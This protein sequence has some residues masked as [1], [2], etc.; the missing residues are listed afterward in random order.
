MCRITYTDASTA[1]RAEPAL[2]PPEAGEGGRDLADVIGIDTGGT[3]TDFVLVRDGTIVTLKAPSTPDD[4]ARAAV[5]GMVT[6]GSEAAVVVHG[7][8]VATNALLE[9]KGARTALVTTAGFEDVL[10]LGRQAR[11][12]LYALEYEAPEPLI[13]PGR[14]V[15]V[16]ERVGAD[17]SVVA[18]LSDADARRVAEAVAALDIEAVAVS[19][20]FSFLRPEHEQRLAAAIER[21]LPEV[22]IS[23]SSDVLPEFRE[24]E[25]ASTVS[26]NAYVGPLMSGYLGR[27][28]QRLNVP[29]RVM[30][31]SGGSTPVELA[32]R[33]PVRTVLSGPAG[34]VIGGMYV[35]EAAGFDHVI[36][37]DMGGT[38]TDVALIPGRVQ[39]TTGHTVGTV[40][41]GVPAVDI[42]TVGA[43]GGSIARVD[44]G[45]ALRVGPESAGAVP[46][47]ACYGVGDEPTVTDA[48]LALGRLVPEHFVGG[49]MS[50]DASRASDAMARVAMAMGAGPTDAALGIVRV[51]NAVMER[52]LRA[53][54]LERGHDPRDFTLVAFGGAGP[55]HACELAAALD[56]GRVLVPRYPGVLSALGVAI[57]DVAKDFSRTVMAR[58]EAS[59]ASVGDAFAVLEAEGVADLAGEG[60]AREGLRIERFVDVRYVGQSFELAVRWPERSA[61]AYADL[62]AAFHQAH[63]QRFGYT[64]PQAPVEVVT[65][66]LRVVAATERPP[67]ERLQPAFGEAPVSGRVEA[68]FETGSRSVALHEREALRPG[69]RLAGPALV[70]QMDAT[71]VLPPGWAGSVDPLGNLI[72]VPEGSGDGH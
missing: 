48:N 34:G 13:A 15:G 41:I 39:L 71:T 43:G 53:V 30:Q 59:L 36:T 6:L 11:S 65:A 23:L 70:V 27:M 55:Q 18:A 69:H 17:G 63:E 32:R 20:L 51:A 45:G 52:A 35:A 64:N 26:A 10:R 12:E 47:P 29:L 5:E 22:F 2:S 44:A 50:L 68:W 49:S 24:Y 8:T 7:T 46:G 33:H 21:L 42:H 4:P 25:R 38:S 1:F 72:L 16:A 66:R 31:S 19:L 28:Q 58:D 40:P 14:S 57:A 67:L 60:F 56:I 37:F 9:R 3:F 61:N 54:S 62:A